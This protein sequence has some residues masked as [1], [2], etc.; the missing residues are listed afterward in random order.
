MGFFDILAAPFKFVGGVIHDIVEVPKSIVHDVTSIP[1]A[2]VETAGSTVNNLV[3]EGG[4]IVI[5]K[6]FAPAAIP[7]YMAKLF[8]SWKLLSDST[9]EL[10][11]AA[12]RPAR[13]GGT[14][15]SSSGLTFFLS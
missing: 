2:L 11:P 6:K 8:M 13:R 1:K 5:P 9:A 4:Q 7:A 15:F 14:A 3:H 12:I 10:Y